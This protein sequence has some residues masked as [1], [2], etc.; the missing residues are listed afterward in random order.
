MVPMMM[1][2]NNLDRFGSSDFTRSSLL[3]QISLCLVLQF[4]NVFHSH[5]MPLVSPAKD[6]PMEVHTN[7]RNETN[8]EDTLFNQPKISKNSLYSLLLQR[9]IAPTPV[10]IY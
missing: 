2:S 9:A 6:L 7:N 5:T 3:F 1:L 10:K 4:T 8:P